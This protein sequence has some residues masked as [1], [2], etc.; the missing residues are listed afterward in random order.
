MRLSAFLHDCSC[1]RHLLLLHPSLAVPFLL[2][3]LLSLLLLLPMKIALKKKYRTSL[4]LFCVYLRACA[5]DVYYLI[6]FDMI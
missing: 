5:A 2:L 1:R 4:F 6:L 3:L